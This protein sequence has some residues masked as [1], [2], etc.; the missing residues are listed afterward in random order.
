M[1][2]AAILASIEAFLPYLS[3]LAPLAQPELLQLEA[4]SMAKLNALIAQETS[5][6]LKALLTGLAGAVDAFAKLEIA[7]L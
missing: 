4:D 3:T 2:F 7:K 1:N 5:P 6:D